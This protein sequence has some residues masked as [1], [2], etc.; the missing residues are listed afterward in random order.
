[1]R[2]DS[3]SFRTE[4]TTA[5]Q[6]ISIKP[7]DTIFC[8]GSCF[9]DNIGQK[10]SAGMMNC[11]SN[12][13]GAAYNPSSVALQIGR[14]IDS[15]PCKNDEIIKTN[16]SFVSYLTHSKIYASSEQK[17]Q[18]IIDTI[19]AQAH[20][21]LKKASLIAITF[22]TAY[23]YTTTDSKAIVANCHKLPANN[24]IRRRLTVD[25]I[26][27]TWLL[28]I[29][30]LR[31]INP[32]AHI[33]FTVSP[34]RHIK[35]TL[36]GN[37][38]SKAI[39]LQAVDKIVNNTDNTSYFEAYEIMLDDLR[40]YR[41]YAEDMIHPSSIA[42]EYIYKHFAEAYLSVNTQQMIADGT[43]LTQAIGHRPINTDGNEY[44]TFIDTTIQ[45][46]ENFRQKYN[47]ESDSYNIKQGVKIL[48]EIKNALNDAKISKNSHNQV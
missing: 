45:R 16:N 14:I 38:I 41:F 34:I 28:T 15:E 1:M 32:N 42:I 17:L 2:P 47:L 37:Q 22:G 19:T 23:T 8:I 3:T 44:R 39:L 29:R 4:I 40:D 26:V 33:V 48:N 9:A 10:L 30:K 21:F 43:K 11:M 35:D 12:P 13:Y 46:L 36:H 31:T 6:I 18:Q 7:T 5:S 27:T 25:E 24:F 20:T